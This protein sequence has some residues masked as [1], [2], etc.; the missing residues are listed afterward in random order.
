MSEIKVDTIAGSTGTTVTIKTGHTLTL[1][2]NMDAGSNKI[3]NVTDPTSAQ[4]VATKNYVDTQLLTLDT[5]GE[6]TDVTISSVGDNEVLAYDSSSSEWINQTASEA[7]LATSGDLTTHSS[8]SS[9]PHSVT[10]SQVGINNTDD[11]SEG[12]TN[13]Y[14][15]ATRFNDAFGLKDTD[16]LTEGSTN[17]YYDNATVIANRLDQFAVPTANLDINS[18]KMTNVTDPT[19]AQDVA[20]KNYVDTQG[21]ADIGLVIALG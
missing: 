8:S 4:D 16:D 7:G 1:V 18:N 17:L 9:N 11:I 15:T 12:S 10:A 20:T 21:F 2:E 14:Y 13:V 5:I 19:S 3:T 6:L